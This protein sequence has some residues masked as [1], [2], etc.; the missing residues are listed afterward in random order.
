[1]APFKKIG[2][3]IL[4]FL[5]SFFVINRML[6]EHIDVLD[7][8]ASYI[9]YPFLTFTERVH[10]MVTSVGETKK[11]YNELTIKCSRLEETCDAQLKEIIKLQ[12]TLRQQEL[13][14]DLIDFQKRYSL[15][16]K[17][18]A[19]ILVHHIGDDEHYVIINRG[20][21]DGVVKDMVALYKFQ[22]L[23]R[24]TDVYP[25]YSKVMLITDR[26]CKVAAYTNSTS[27]HGIVLGINNSMRCEF[28]YVSHLFKVSDD[29][30][31]FSSG[32]GLVFPEGFC[33]GKI[34]RH[35]LQEKSLYHEV[36]IEPLFNVAQLKYCLLTDQS[37]INLF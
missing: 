20:E 18:L 10:E 13:C 7:R 28:A 37:K 36:E 24:V 27:A 4:L 1:M 30:L 22:I 32:Q 35:A 23:G 12:S 17:M 8:V 3:G 19:K 14:Q 2:L 26:R 6:I 31:I 5:F 33:L 34:V 11:S 9:A 21:Q 16:N 15:E 25:W 29:D